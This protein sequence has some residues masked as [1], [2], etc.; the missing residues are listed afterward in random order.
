MVFSVEGIKRGRK[1]KGLKPGGQF[2][3]WIKLLFLYLK[4]NAYEENGHII[5]DAPFGFDEINYDSLKFSFI[6]GSVDEMKENM[7]K[8]EP[9]AGPCLR[10]ALPLTVPTFQG[11]EIIYC[12]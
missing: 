7:I 9:A 3:H 4:V 11:M 2:M 8:F 10:F 12:I 1:T 5:L 6:G